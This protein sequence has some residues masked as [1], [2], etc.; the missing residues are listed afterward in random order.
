[1]TEDQIERRVETRMNALDRKLLMGVLTQD[2]Y[3]L[4]VKQLD[5]WAQAEY[6]T[7]LRHSRQG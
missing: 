3:D 7:L 1:M 5:Q 4:A 2:D 6:S